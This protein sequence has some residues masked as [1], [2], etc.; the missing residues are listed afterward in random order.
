MGLNR[1]TIWRGLD[2]GRLTPLLRSQLER[3]LFLREQHKRE[4][5]EARVE[6]L[7]ARLQDVEQQLRGRLN[8]SPDGVG[9]WRAYHDSEADERETSVAAS[10]VD[11]SPAA[12]AASGEARAGSEARPEYIPSRIYPDVV[13]PQA[14]PGEER[15][16]RRGH[17]ADR[18]MA[19]GRCRAGIGP[20]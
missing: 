4:Q 10:A 1:K 11:G 17:G 18:R 8:G 20:G 9:P 15:G 5:L 19:R 2:G 6:Q 7:A 16:L 3:E 13:T 14:E 12:E